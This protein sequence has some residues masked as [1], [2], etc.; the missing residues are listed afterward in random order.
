MEVGTSNIDL[1]RLKCVFLNFPIL[2][3][4]ILNIIYIILYII[5]YISLKLY[6]I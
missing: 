4:N 2:V 5:I 1:L 3:L 6:S